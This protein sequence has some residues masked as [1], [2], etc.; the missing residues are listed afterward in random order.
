MGEA[1][2]IIVLIL[3][4][5]A[6]MF[7]VAKYVR[8]KN[9]TRVILS[10]MLT[11][12]LIIFSWSV[13]AALYATDE[14]AIVLPFFLIALVVHLSIPVVGTGFIISGRRK[15]RPASVVAGVLL[16]LAFLGF[17]FAMF[18]VPYL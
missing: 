10:S 18:I 8:E 6:S 3:V 16:W 1:I 17:N 12:F 11:V 9:V 5:F 15:K 14:E 4:P 2:A 13:Y 7:L